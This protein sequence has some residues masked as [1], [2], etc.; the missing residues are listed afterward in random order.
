MLQKFS[1]SMS[2]P[3]SP[4][5][6]KTSLS[7]NHLPFGP[8]HQ[9]PQTILHRH[10]HCGNKKDDHGVCLLQKRV[11]ERDLLIAFFCDETKLN[12]ATNVLVKG[13]TS[14]KRRRTSEN[15]RRRG[16]H[17]S[18]ASAERQIMSQGPSRQSRQGPRLGRV[19][20]HPCCRVQPGR[21]EP[22]PQTQDAP[23]VFSRKTSQASRA[24]TMVSTEK[25]AA[26][27]GDPAR[28]WQAMACR[29]RARSSPRISS[30]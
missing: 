29:S 7:P 23:R 19:H 22:E 18:G 3:S 6:S 1:G 17:H 30:G 10:T 9:L 28:E 26:Q 24:F 25:H 11:G 4:L 27:A 14:G 12:P 5:S 21:L 8:P 20:V 15:K 16:A 2:C 13:G